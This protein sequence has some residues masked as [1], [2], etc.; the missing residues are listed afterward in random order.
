VLEINGIKFDNDSRLK[1]VR[2][3][4]VDKKGTT[5]TVEGNPAGMGAAFSIKHELE[6]HP[7]FI[8]EVPIGA[9]T[10]AIKEKP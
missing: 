9:V 5:L 10:M 2:L 1:E 7:T 6:D 4:L 3:V 8:A